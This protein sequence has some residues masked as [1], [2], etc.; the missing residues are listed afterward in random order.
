MVSIFRMDGASSPRS[1]V[2]SLARRANLPLAEDK[3]TSSLSRFGSSTCKPIRRSRRAGTC[4]DPL[5]VFR[6][7]P[8][9]CRARATDA[10]LLLRSH[11]KD[12]EDTKRRANLQVKDVATWQLA[13]ASCFTTLDCAIAQSRVVTVSRTKRTHA[14]D[15]G[16][17]ER[18][19]PSIV[20]LERQAAGDA[21]LPCRL[22][23]PRA[24]CGLRRRAFA[25]ILLLR[26]LHYQRQVGMSRATHGPQP[27]RGAS[28]RGVNL[29]S[30]QNTRASRDVCSSVHVEPTPDLAGAEIRAINPVVARVR[31]ISEHPGGAIFRSV[32]GN[33]L[34][35]VAEPLH[36]PVAE[37]GTAALFQPNPALW[38]KHQFSASSRAC[39]HSWAVFTFLH[40]ARRQCGTLGETMRSR[41]SIRRMERS[42]R[43]AAASRIGLTLGSYS[44]KSGSGI[45]G[46]SRC[47]STATAS[48]L[49]WLR[50]HPTASWVM[51]GRSHE[52]TS[53]RA[54]GLHRSTERTPP[55]GPPT[56]GSSLRR[57]TL[58][59]LPGTWPLPTSTISSAAALAARAIFSRRNSWRIFKRLLGKPM[60]PLP[61]PIRIAARVSKV[62]LVSLKSYPHARVKAK[63]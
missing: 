39:C 30:A 3:A 14:A 2:A 51:K 61:P 35:L 47:G 55:R 37:H 21:L 62:L 23:C 25:G 54:A 11:S 17:R 10:A 48:A 59:S 43:C 56:P 9:R 26:N 1:A 42:P 36:A 28:S 57:G 19:G 18:G 27:F 41:A 24:G 29:V 22:V 33:V 58:S 45:P 49:D 13:G 40:A 53:H 15:R 46:E 6:F 12:I 52:N 32:P 20:P 60:R 5:L 4:R 38:G 16:K 63:W 7:S 50:S 8:H 31:V 34:P 44:A